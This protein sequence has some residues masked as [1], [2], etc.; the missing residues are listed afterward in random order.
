MYLAPLL[1]KSSRKVAT[2]IAVCLSYL[3]VAYVPVLTGTK[4]FVAG[5]VLL[6]CPHVCIWRAHH[7]Q[8]NKLCVAVV[9]LAFTL[10]LYGQQT[11][12]L[13]PTRTFAL[14]SKALPVLYALFSSKFQLH[15]LLLYT[16]DVYQ[17]IRAILAW[18]LVH[19]Q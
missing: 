19:M 4:Q 17:G 11:K 1:Q 2:L 8:A 18:R 9:P 10:Y 5:A 16:S 14:W 3:F 6:L 12:R 7:H 15:M 13:M